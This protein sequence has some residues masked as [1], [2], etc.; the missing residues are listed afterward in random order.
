MVNKQKKAMENKEL[1][2]MDGARIQA[3]TMKETNDAK[4]E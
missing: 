3:I 1:I 2:K 4:E